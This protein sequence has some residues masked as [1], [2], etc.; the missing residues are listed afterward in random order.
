VWVFG[1]ISD[2]VL[3]E[4]KLKREQGQAVRYFK[5][6][7]DYPITFRANSGKTIPFEDP[8]LEEFRYLLV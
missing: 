1:E 5:I 6:G 7:E 2:G 8:Q 4:V 3:A